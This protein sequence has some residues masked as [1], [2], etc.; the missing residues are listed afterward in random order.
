MR[1][2]IFSRRHLC[3]A[4]LSFS[5][6]F[7][8]C[9]GSAAPP[10]PATCIDAVARMGQLRLED[11]HPKMSHENAR[12]HAKQIANAASGQAIAACGQL[13]NDK[14]RELAECM[15]AAETSPQGQRCFLAAN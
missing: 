13:S 11:R 14:K 10:D 4:L 3:A 2:T 5:V 1:E 8:G 6:A 7:L 9:Q 12:R 15:G